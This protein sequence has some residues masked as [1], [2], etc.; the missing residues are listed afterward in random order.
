MCRIFSQSFKAKFE[1]FHKVKNEN[2]RY[3]YYPLGT[4]SWCE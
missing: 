1:K 3:V 4:D 2:P